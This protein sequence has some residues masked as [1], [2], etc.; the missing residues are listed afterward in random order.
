[1]HKKVASWGQ[2]CLCKI[3]RAYTTLS[4]RYSDFSKNG[5]NGDLKSRDIS[6]TAE[7]HVLVTFNQTKCIFTKNVCAKFGVSIYNNK[8]FISN[9]V[10]F[11][12]PSLVLP[13]CHNVVATLPKVTFLCSGLNAPKNELLHD[14]VR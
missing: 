12:R 5:K 4:P 9:L 13:R 2:E 3:S 10:F 1:M 8:D 14:F 11:S 6:K 7:S